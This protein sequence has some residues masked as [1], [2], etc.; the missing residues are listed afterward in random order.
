[1]KYKGIVF[2]LDGLGDR[3][4]PQLKGNTPLQAA[5]T[6]TLDQLALNNQCGMMDP[7][8]PGITVDTHTGVGVLF[9]LSPQDALSLRRGPIEAA[10]ID[11]ESSPEDVLLRANF[12]TVEKHADGYQ[13]LDRR[14]GRIEDDTDLLCTALKDIEV[15]P[16]ITAS[17]HAATQHR[18]VL[19]LHG[20]NLSPEI[21]DT[22][23]GG[24]EIERGILQ[25]T[26]RHSD[27]KTDAK[28]TATADAL[29]CFTHRAYEILENH[30]VNQRR[31]KQGLPS[32]NGIIARSA[33]VRQP[34]NNL[35]AR[36]DLKVAAVA[37]EMTILGLAKL[38][39]FDCYTSPSFTSLPNTDIA[40]KLRTAE[41][42]LKDHDLVFVHVKGT[43][44]AAH[45]KD[46]VLKSEVIARFDQELSKLKLDNLIIG[47]CADHSTGSLSGEHN[48]DP[49][50]VLISNP[51]GRRD[52]V[53]GYNET[54]CITGALGRINAQGFLTTLLDAMG[55]L[56][57]RNLHD[58]DYYKP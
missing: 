56:A 27:K 54:D 6:P 2:I 46:P 31:I 8:S 34:L 41:R 57:S 37:G 23:P 53:S 16:G 1:M 5:A 28:A 47:V 43:D 35:L 24:T 15:A 48:G 38:F 51:V 55:V 44:T 13:I 21:S 40:E 19:Q 11:L 45:D 26:L 4:C 22:D 42:A 7:L 52:H 20:K 18:T 49:V 39:D 12:A 10:G 9:G 29:N 3:P 17:L 36:I 50:P 58:L 25:S 30:E 14:A 33:G 32:A